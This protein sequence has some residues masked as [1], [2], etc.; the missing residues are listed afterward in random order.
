[1]NK[2]KLKF[3]ILIEFQSLKGL[4]MSF[5]VSAKPDI[6]TNADYRVPSTKT[7]SLILQWLQSTMS[8]A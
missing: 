4:G 3:H 7:V 2:K 6:E 1:M 8:Q 5:R